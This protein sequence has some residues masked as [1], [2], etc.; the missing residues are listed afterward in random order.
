MVTARVWG[1]PECRAR[2]EAVQRCC[3]DGEERTEPPEA[4][5]EASPLGQGEHRWL[6]SPGHTAAPHP[7]GQADALLNSELARAW[8]GVSRSGSEVEGHPDRGNR[9]SEAPEQEGF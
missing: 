7:E 3:R 1:Q 8:V 6:L 2:E 9:V 4:Q 5:E